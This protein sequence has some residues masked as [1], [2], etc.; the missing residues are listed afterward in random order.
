MA[1]VNGMYYHDG[2]AYH[3]KCGSSLTFDEICSHYCNHCREHIQGSKLEASNFCGAHVICGAS[4]MGECTNKMINCPKTSEWFKNHCPANP[5]WIKLTKR[6]QLWND[7]IILTFISKRQAIEMLNSGEAE[8]IT[9]Q[10]IQIK[11]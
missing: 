1:Q 9:N 7:R 10:A 11:N 5:E 4:T 8:V 6:V 2:K 3:R